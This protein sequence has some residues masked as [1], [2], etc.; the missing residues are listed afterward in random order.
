MLPKVD[1][2]ALNDRL[3]NE[4]IGGSQPRTRNL[5]RANQRARMSDFRPPWW[6]R[7]RHLQTLWPTLVRRRPALKT[8]RERLELPDGDFL[9]LNWVGAG[10]G[11][12]VVVLHGLMGSIRSPYATGIMRQIERRGWR[13][14]FVH[15]RGCSG[16]PNRLPR[17]YHSGD[18][19]DLAFV[20]EEMNR[21]EP[22]THIAAIGY[23]LG[24]NA[25]LKWLGETKGDNPLTAAVAV[26][27]PYDLAQVADSIHQGFS[28]IYERRLVRSLQRMVLAKIETNPKAMPVDRNRLLQLKTFWSFDDEA[29]APLHGFVDAR[30]YYTRSSARQ[31]LPDIRT[32]S[33]ILHARDDPFMTP[34]VIPTTEEISK[35]TTQEISEHGGHVGFVS[36]SWPWK[37]RYWLEERIPAFLVEHFD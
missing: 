15:F 18:T 17:F 2:N 33:L 10:S 22:G 6:L 5:T 8:R 1:S 28:R 34:D 37:P 19:G 32:P 31:F 12:I 24:G 21:R 35:S 26:S 20:I 4:Q 16:E 27:V 36:G 7:N 3:F 9:D 25:L 23:S 11:P 30:D 29:T 13:G 14:L